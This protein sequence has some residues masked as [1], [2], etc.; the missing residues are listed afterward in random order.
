MG[1]NESKTI[2]KP[3]ISKYHTLKTI[4]VGDSGVGKS[5]LLYRFIDDQ[6]LPEGTSTIGVEFG[7][8]TLDILGIRIK[9]HI[10]DTAGQEKFRAVTRSYYHGANCALLVFDKTCRSSFKNVQAWL[11]DV[12]NLCADDVKII[13]VGNK[14][15]L[16]DAC[17]VPTSEAD[18]FAQEYSI[19]YIETSAKTGEAV[20]EAF[21]HVSHEAVRSL[22][23]KGKLS[24]NNDK[25]VSRK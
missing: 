2:V 25:Y 16:E 7:T 8:K 9:I 23:N 24:I 18:S 19:H 22:I 17:D 6:F 15:D 13:L 3:N 21:T 5:S 12:K 1:C 4:I 14:K 10:W 11:T 20:S